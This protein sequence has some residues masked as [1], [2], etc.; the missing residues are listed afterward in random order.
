MAF[1]F[2]ELRLSTKLSAEPLILKALSDAETTIES[3]EQH[4]VAIIQGFVVST[5]QNFR[6]GSWIWG[7]LYPRKIVG[8]IAMVALFAVW[9]CAFVSLFI[10]TNDLSVQ[11]VR[12]DAGKRVITWSDEAP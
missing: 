9:I 8:L 11:G 4:D 1:S 12:E 10:L 3:G 5:T 6:V 2:E 7:A